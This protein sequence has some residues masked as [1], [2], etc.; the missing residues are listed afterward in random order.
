MRH[1]IVIVMLVLPNIALADIYVLSDKETGIIYSLSNQDD[2]FCPKSADK[3]I[4]KGELREL[5][6]T[7]PSD[8]YIFKKGK[9]KLDAKRL[10]SESIKEEVSRKKA[11]RK[12]KIKAK[13]EKMAE[14]A[15]I[16]SGELEVE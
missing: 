13:A 4:I 3:N 12:A 10:E 14:Q 2:A 7:Y 5:E 11:I 16:A 8:Y 1:L 15:L 9:F 6:L